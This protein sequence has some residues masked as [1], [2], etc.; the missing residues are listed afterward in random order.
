[1]FEHSVLMLHT[2][3]DFE[4]ANSTIHPFLIWKCVK[5]WKLLISK[6]AQTW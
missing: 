5:I 1:M 3:P 2:I 6:E 4:L